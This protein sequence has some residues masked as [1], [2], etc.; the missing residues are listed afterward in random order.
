MKTLATTILLTLVTLGYL[1]PAYA[2]PEPRKNPGHIVKNLPKKHQVVKLRRHQYY[3]SEGVFYNNT[4]GNFVV[5]NA[6]IGAVIPVLSG[7]YTTFGIGLHRYFYLSGTYYQKVATGYEVIRQP[8]EA[9]AALAAGSD[10]LIVY[11]AAGQ[12]DQ[13]KD[14]D[15]YECHV[16]AR[17]ETM[18]D[19]SNPDSDPVFRSDYQRAMS[20]CLE[21]RHYVVR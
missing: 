9:E 20:A 12:S 6:P 8:R 14:K 16:W 15:Q 21:A 5:V 10:R 1:S 3:F 13:V 11:P 4:R 19:P 2:I 17:D 18:F 7:R